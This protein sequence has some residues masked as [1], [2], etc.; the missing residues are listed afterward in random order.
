[1]YKLFSAIIAILFL[2][3]FNSCVPANKL[4]YFHDLTPSTQKIDSSPQVSQ[5][6]I[7][8]GDRVAII[9]SCPDPTQTAFLNALNNQNTGT[10][11]QQMNGYK[12]DED[13]T[14]DFPLIGT[15]QIAGL[16][17][18]EAATL[19]RKKLEFYY[20]DPYVAVNLSGRVFFMNGRA[21]TTI[22][23]VNER[24]TIFEAIAQSGA[25]DAF[26]KK[27]EVWLVREENGERTF[28]QLNLND[29]TIFKSPYYYLHNNDLVYM[30]PGKFTSFFVT[31]SPARN[32]L[33]IA[34]AALTLYFAFKKF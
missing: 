15:I 27:N 18:K 31:N 1:M 2:L 10:S 24:L 32:I 6:K 14:I 3:S 22:P 21:G 11:S 28:I 4:Y 12:V 5:I 29:K 16:S 19:I 8:K 13:G 23:M 20:K 25:Q 7:M 9:V 17:S 34:G 30:Q 26:D 33:T